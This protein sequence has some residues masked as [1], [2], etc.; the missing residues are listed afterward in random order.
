M[1]RMLARSMKNQI[2]TN[3]AYRRVVAALDDCEKRYDG[4]I[5]RTGATND[6]RL[7]IGTARGRQALRMQRKR[8]CHLPE[9]RFP[10]QHAWQALADDGFKRMFCAGNVISRMRT[11]PAPLVL[12]S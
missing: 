10:P 6:S 8:K 5:K 1:P 2:A 12:I 11:W 3:P 9:W 4:L 7:A